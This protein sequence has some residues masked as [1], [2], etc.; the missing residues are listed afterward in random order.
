M[1]RK[2]FKSIKESISKNL[3]PNDWRRFYSFLRAK[4]VEVFLVKII[5]K[6][7]KLSNIQMHIITLLKIDF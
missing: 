5:V 4:S 2:D 6:N 7:L 3:S 1:T